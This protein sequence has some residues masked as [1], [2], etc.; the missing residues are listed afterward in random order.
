MQCYNL[1]RVKLNDTYDDFEVN[2]DANSSTSSVLKC[3][4]GILL[5]HWTPLEN[6]SNGSIAFRG[7]VYIAVC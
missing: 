1:N 2:F 4:N 3:E 5:P 6:V 7:I